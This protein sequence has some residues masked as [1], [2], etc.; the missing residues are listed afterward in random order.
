MIR[1]KPAAIAAWDPDFDAWTIETIPPGSGAQAAVGPPGPA[2]VATIRRGGASLSIC[3]MTGRVAALWLEDE[4][5]PPGRDLLDAFTVG[6]GPV[7]ADG[8]IEVPLAPV[9]ARLEVTRIALLTDAGATAGLPEAGAAGFL[10]QAERAAVLARLAGR[11]PRLAP[12][13]VVIDARERADWAA[14]ALASEDLRDLLP[15]Q[16]RLDPATAEPALRAIRGALRRA[17]GAPP[18]PAEA[19]LQ[20]T[21]D[22][23]VAGRPASPPG[24]LAFRGAVRATERFVAFPDLFAQPPIA[25]LRSIGEG[26]A[27]SAPGPRGPV[28]VAPIV[29]EAVRLGDLAPRQVGLA[30]DGTVRMSGNWCAVEV[31]VPPTGPHPGRCWATA[32]R[33]GRPLGSAPFTVAGTSAVAWVATTDAPDAIAVSTDPAR[34]TTPFPGAD[35]ASVTRLGAA[36]WW[37]RCLGHPGAAS[38]SSRAAVAWLELGQPFRA[39][40]ASTLADRAEVD[41]QLDRWIG[42]ARSAAA[43]AT[44]DAVA[45]SGDLPPP[46]QAPAIGPPAWLHAIDLAAWASALPDR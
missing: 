7:R 25:A 2:G 28:L 29:G 27:S 4:L 32:L 37:G 15:S 22:A 40:W 3:V 8:R 11:H 41:R 14:V 16:V 44:L 26:G 43:R 36:A 20:T 38:W 42:G 31:P 18:S 21:A 1:T 17:G 34:R 9:A 46:E 5:D 35:L 13:E 24:G 23:L 39:G 10:L 19:A 6:E 12:P 30:P 45:A 33:A